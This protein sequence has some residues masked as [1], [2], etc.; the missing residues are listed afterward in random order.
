MAERDVQNTLDASQSRRA[1]VEPE[2]GLAAPD[3]GEDGNAGFFVETPEV[4]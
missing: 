2:L 3:P 1:D 4:S